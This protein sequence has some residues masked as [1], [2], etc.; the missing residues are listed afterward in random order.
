MRGCAK[1]LP[2][3][4][5]VE[6]LMLI[7]HM[8]LVYLLSW[9]RRC[10]CRRLINNITAVAAVWLDWIDMN[11]VIRPV[12]RLISTLFFDLIWLIIKNWSFYSNEISLNFAVFDSILKTNK[13]IFSID[14]SIP[15]QFVWIESDTEKIPHQNTKLVTEKIH[16]IKISFWHIFAFS[17]DF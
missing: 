9:S 13:L 14:I 15:Y 16:Q 6:W 5:K 11:E 7:T 17:L 3:F 2:Y 10:H 1:R 12:G 8:W 4:S